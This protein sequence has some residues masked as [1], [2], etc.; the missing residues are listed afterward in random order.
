[1][2]FGLT[3][4]GFVPMTFEDIRADINARVWNTISPTLDLSDRTY[5]GQL[6]AIVAYHLAL[7]WELGEANNSQL[8]PDKA[9]DALLDA[10]CLLTGTFRAAASYSTVTLTLTGDPSTLI[11]EGH[12]ARVT[13][14]P[15]FDTDDDVTLETVDDW[16]TSTMYAVGDR[17]TSNGNVYQCTTA[18]ESDSMTGP[19]SVDPLEDIV[20]NDAHWRFLGEGTAAGDVESTATETGPLAANS[21]TITEIVTPV[22]GWN[23][24]VNVLDADVGRN[25]MTNA[26]LRILRELE[27]AQPGTCTQDAIRSALL[28][29]A[30]VTNV[31]V[32]VN[33]TDETNVDDMPPHSVEAMVQGG[34]DQDI[35]DALLANVAAGIQTTGT[36]EGTAIDSQGTEHTEKFTRPEEIP[37]YVEIDLIIDADTYPENGDDLVA[38]AIVAWGDAQ[39][40]GKDAVASRIGYASFDVDG[41]LDVTAV[42]IGLAP[43]PTLDDTIEIDLRQLATY[44]T[45]RITVATTPGTP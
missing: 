36:E 26:E 7:L 8:D 22:G 37:I 25:R 40:T 45:S 19:S 30:G 43:G 5:E 41:V 20:D 9:M 15:R 34:E 13:D 21:G 1:M 28:Q 24:V 39:A 29:V 14:G 31:T 44:D 27:L 16:A 17:V 38:E 35:W 42:R 4:E 2:A 3:P 32:F 11:T 18:G 6:I 33:N 10:I 23:G 12:A